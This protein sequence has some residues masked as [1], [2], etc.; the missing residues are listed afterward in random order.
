MQFEPIMRAVSEA[1]SQQRLAEAIGVTQGFISQMLSGAKR[2]PASLCL[3]IER[4]TGVSRHELR[5]DIYP[6]EETA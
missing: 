2:V 5:P 6:I 3:P 1:G 4:A